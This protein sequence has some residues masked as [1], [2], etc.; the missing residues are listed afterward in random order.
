MVLGSLSSESV[1]RADQRAKSSG[2]E[3][4]TMTE[5]AVE[6]EAN[7]SGGGAGGRGEEGRQRGEERGRE[8]LFLSGSVESSADSSQSYQLLQ[9]SADLIKTNTSSQ[10]HHNHVDQILFQEIAIRRRVR[11]ESPH[12]RDDCKTHGCRAVFRTDRNFWLCC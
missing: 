4:V 6:Y 10:Q 1:E 12:T 5:D 3:K 9:S 2:T 7:W 8:G 11:D